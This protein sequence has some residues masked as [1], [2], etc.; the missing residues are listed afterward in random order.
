MKTRFTV[1][2]I[3]TTLVAITASAQVQLPHV[4]QKATVSQTVGLTDVTI[5]YSRPGVKGRAIWGGLVPYDQ[6]W[7]TGAN[8][9]TKITFSNDVTVNGEKLAA[10]SYSLHTIPSKDEWT[11]I[12]NKDADQW[13][14][15]SYDAAKDALRIKVK[16]EQEPFQEWMQFSFPAATPSSAT[17]ELRWENLRVPFTIEAGTATQ[18]M[19][20]ARTSV[21]NMDNWRTPYAA[22]NYAYDSNADNKDEAMKWTDRSIALNANFWN[23]RLKANMLARDGNFKAAIPLAEKAVQSGKEKKEEAS[24]IEK[25]EKTLADWKAKK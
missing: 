11:V 7:R 16:P 25:T 10:G 6:V 5:T 19:K 8:E 22:A 17:V 9:A 23:L 21:E 13:G 3:L 15:Y 1:V 24:E 18:A 14:S 2:L 4:S 12:F 20:N